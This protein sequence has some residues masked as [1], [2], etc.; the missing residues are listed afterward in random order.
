MLG[1]EPD[2]SYFCH[3]Y[4]DGMQLAGD[5]AEFSGIDLSGDFHVFGVLWEAEQIIWYVDDIE[6]RRIQRQN[7][8]V[9]MC[10]LLTVGVGGWAGVPDNTTEFPAYLYVDYVKVW[11]R[12]DIMSITAN[13]QLI[14]A[15]LRNSSLELAAQADSI[16]AVIIE[17][18]EL[19]NKLD[20][21]KD[22]IEEDV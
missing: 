17:L 10:I 21:L 2:R 8:D 15:D 18:R 16:A 13:L 5:C 4:W 6:Y 22:I 9:D 7:A 1:S 14:E 12:E 3:H 20:A 19:D 11:K